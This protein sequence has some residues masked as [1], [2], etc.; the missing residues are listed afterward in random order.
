ML[1]E[2]FG[3]CSPYS[4]TLAER[5]NCVMINWKAQEAVPGSGERQASWPGEDSP[6]EFQEFLSLLSILPVKPKL[7]TT[8]STHLSPETSRGI[9]T[10]IK[11]PALVRQQN[12][13]SLKPLLVPLTS[14]IPFLRFTEP[15]TSPGALVWGPHRFTVSG[16]PQYP[17]PT[18]FP[19]H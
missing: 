1:C 8:N 10:P 6:Q 4:L 15:T 18:L 5:K 19:H 7:R 9:R 14:C 16:Y 17:A 12:R 3:L 13:H 11:K 2:L